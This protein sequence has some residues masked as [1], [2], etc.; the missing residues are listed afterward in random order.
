M[1][2]EYERGRRRTK[3]KVQHWA[4]VEARCV[5]HFCFP[6]MSALRPGN[7][8]LDCRMYAFSDQPLGGC[9]KNYTP[10]GARL[11]FVMVK[12]N[13]TPDVAQTPVWSLGHTSLQW[14]LSSV[15]LYQH[16]RHWRALI[17]G[18]FLKFKIFHW[19]ILSLKTGFRSSPSVDWWLLFLHSSVW[20]YFTNVAWSVKLKCTNS[21]MFL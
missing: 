4:E 5:Q 15:N 3:T 13:Q 18:M 10:R 7:P 19:L 1:D 8:V 11:C 20:I 6:V 21:L 9:A 17:E 14:L 16:C 2:D 12:W